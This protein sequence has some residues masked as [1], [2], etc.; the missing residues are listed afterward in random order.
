MKI[1]RVP[2]LSFVFLVKRRITQKTKVYNINK[3]QSVVI[4]LFRETLNQICKF[5]FSDSMAE[6]LA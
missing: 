1:L 2:I 6:S 5:K 4:K 3:P